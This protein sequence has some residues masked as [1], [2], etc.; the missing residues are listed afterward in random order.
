MSPA[1]IWLFA[2]IALCL[3][4]L[5]LPTTF[6]VFNLG[7]AAI[8]VSLVALVLPA[9]NLLIALWVVF[10]LLGVWASRRFLAPKKQ[11]RDL[12]DDREGK[13]LTIIPPG[14]TGRV[15]YEGNSWQAQCV[16]KTMSISV[17][18]SVYVVEI[19][20]NTLIVLPS[21]LLL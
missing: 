9:A 7:L 1:L 19:K 4:E 21:N 3:A 20:G 11:R 18:E 12:G 8:L 17:A 16:E 13:T 15:L 6:I 2:G 10:A 5:V 14:K